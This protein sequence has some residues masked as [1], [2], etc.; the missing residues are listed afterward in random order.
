M[1]IGLYSVQYPGDLPFGG[2][3]VY[4]A[5]LAAAMVR[6]GH[7]VHVF[8]L[9]YDDCSTAVEHGVHVHRIQVPNRSFV[10]SILFRRR[11]PAA[12]REVSD[13]I[14]G[15]DILHTN[16]QYVITGFECPTILTVHHVVA[17]LHQTFA[18][19]ALRGDRNP[20]ILRSER[21]SVGQADRI[22]T[23]SPQSKKDLIRFYP[24]VA[25]KT[26]AVLNGV[27]VAAFHAADDD[28]TDCRERLGLRPGQLLIVSSPGN[29]EDERKGLKYM[30]EAF[31]QF[32]EGLDWKCVVLGRGSSDG[33]SK[34]LSHANV[35]P[36]VEFPGFVS[37]E[38][39]IDLLN[40]ADLFT[41]PSLLEG[42][43]TAMLEALAARCAVASTIV[44]GIPDLI[45]SEDQ[46]LLVEAEDTAAFRDAMLTLLQ[47]DQRRRRIAD[48]N[49]RI[50]LQELTW[51]A[52]AEKT[53]AVYVNAIE[54]RSRAAS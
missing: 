39:K 25:D 44:G 33:Y 28:Q 13:S 6:A 46:G 26:T 49:R 34:W 2:A 51:E 43:P 20:W 30:F 48:N 23:V 38:H 19:P 35:A 12:L 50:A 5:E 31:T 16:E 32:P 9:S 4:S 42:C 40:A 52:T 27:D 7:E 36:R 45:R 8:I 14:G 17:V 15:F 18:L 54:E 21:K 53:L 24:H 37:R 29:L 41:M 10:R 1:K 3:G 22:V 11:L 47:D